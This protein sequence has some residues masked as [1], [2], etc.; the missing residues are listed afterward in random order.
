MS[1]MSHFPF[2]TYFYFSKSENS[3][4]ATHSAQIFMYGEVGCR[5]QPLLRHMS[6]SKGHG[7]CRPAYDGIDA[8]GWSDCYHLRRNQERS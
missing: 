6:A 7:D 2:V 1:A 3:K 4:K 5:R 8:S